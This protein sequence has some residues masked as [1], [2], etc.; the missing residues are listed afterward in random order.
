MFTIDKTVR[1]GFIGYGE[2]PYHLS[3]HFLPGSVELYA[4][5]KIQEQ[6]GGKAEKLRA[7]AAENG[8]VLV[9]DLSELL[10]RGE[11]FFNFTSANAAVPMAKEVAPLL[12]EGQV[13][14]DM[15]STAPQTK[16]AIADCFARS[17]GDFV[18]AA[19]MS[20]VPANS[21]R[22]P[23]SLCGKKGDEVSRRLN[24][25][26][27]NTTFLQEEIG[28]A[29]ATKILRSILAKGLIA[30]LTETVFAT[31]RYHITEEVLEKMRRT[32]FEEMSFL[33]FCHYSVASAA[34][35][36]ERFCHEM[37]ECIKT[38]DL[39]GENSIMTQA[40]LQKFQWL[41]EQGFSG[42]FS[43]RPKT[44]HEVLDV[45]YSLESGA[46]ENG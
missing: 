4:Y 1:L 42:F 7:H 5:D 46:R 21:T 25:L 29:S 44:Y 20:S 24:A 17:A 10:L 18:E 9:K 2:A 8:V 13:Y 19:V 35:H 28:L 33:E 23:I 30:L 14:L 27:M 16:Q 6:E 31:E 36:N 38:L 22:V 3:K 34:I 40:T 11:I 32:M 26:G 41:H 15:N 37:S 12:R 43:E 45:K 39:L